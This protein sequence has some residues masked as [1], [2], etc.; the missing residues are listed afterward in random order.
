MYKSKI[1]Y[2]VCFFIF[3][4]LVGGSE[5]F[6][7][8]VNSLVI[9][10]QEALEIQTKVESHFSNFKTKLEQNGSVK[11]Y[12]EN[13][14]SVEPS[15]GYYVLKTP[16]LKV[17]TYKYKRRKSE[18]VS[19][20]LDIGTIVAHI[21]PVSSPYND[22]S[23]IYSISL[24]V[25][26][27][28][29]ISGL[30]KD[31]VSVVFKDQ[32]IHLVWASDLNIFFK[33]FYDFK[34]IKFLAKNT[35]TL[36]SLASISVKSDI[37]RDDQNQWSGTTHV[38]GQDIFVGGRNQIKLGDFDYEKTFEAI[39]NN[40]L[41]SGVEYILSAV[42]LFTNNPSKDSL[43][44][45]LTFFTNFFIDESDHE[46]RLSLKNI[47]AYYGH[48]KPHFS[49][50][51]LNFFGAIRP[52]EDDAYHASFQMKEFLPG[53]GYNEIPLLSQGALPLNTNV[54]FLIKNLPSERN[55]DEMLEKTAVDIENNDFR[56]SGI[57]SSGIIKRNIVSMLQQAGLTVNFNKI[58][59]GSLDYAVEAKGDLQY[60]YNSDAFVSQFDII[61]SGLNKL[62]KRSQ[63][64]VASGERSEL[65][66]A[67]FLATYI[68]VL[69][70]LGPPLERNAT[71]DADVNYYRFE[72]THNNQILFNGV[73]IESIKQQLGIQTRKQK[74]RQGMESLERLDQEYERL[75]SHKSIMEPVERKPKKPAPAMGKE[76]LMKLDF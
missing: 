56:K 61:L 60:I 74:K 52:Q 62:L 51:Y 38:N 17:E 44:T 7:Q 59:L 20:T 73:D 3:F 43:L 54:D 2:G 66:E 16:H 40:E 53:P 15:N 68:P 64:I 25:P 63:E 48:E 41:E 32:N 10:H 22:I 65:N 72:S 29:T 70:L 69:Q 21:V 12:A 4:A 36:F 45:F 76:E 57:F 28:I 49:V 18:P 35:S 71:P 19:I 23:N 67:K 30:N 24:A 46:M 37:R 55:I 11:V 26:N 13:G 42:D 31:E 39:A 5:V 47:G 27:D 14:F 33:V 58:Y 50:Q 9:T 1:V 75:E 8:N 6:A 34:D